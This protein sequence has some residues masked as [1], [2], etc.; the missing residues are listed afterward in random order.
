MVPL[1]GQNDSHSTETIASDTIDSAVG[2]LSLRQQARPWC[3]YLTLLLIDASSRVA[4][5]VKRQAANPSMG[6]YRVI[7]SLAHAQD[8]LR[9][10]AKSKLSV[11]RRALV[12]LNEI[13]DDVNVAYSLATSIPEGIDAGK[14]AVARS[15]D[16]SVSPGL[17]PMDDWM[18]D[19]SK[20][21]HAAELA[22]LLSSEAFP[23]DS[24]P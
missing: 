1:Q 2:Y 22:D 13:S 11:T 4:P 5:I 16:K 9:D 18:F 10:L 23:L 21:W 3:T 6:A 12:R 7:L 24:G 19:T 17:L 8:C 20:I 14:D 15:I